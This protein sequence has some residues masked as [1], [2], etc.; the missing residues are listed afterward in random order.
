MLRSA[1]TTTTRPRA[2]ASR[3]EY[4]LFLTSRCSLRV[5]NIPWAEQVAEDTRSRRSRAYYLRPPSMSSRKTDIRSQL[6]PNLGCPTLSRS[7]SRPCKTS[8]V[9]FVRSTRC[10]DSL[11]LSLA[12][13]NSRSRSRSSLLALRTPHSALSL[14]VRSRSTRM[15]ALA[16]ALG[17][18]HSLSHSIR[19]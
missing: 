4:R 5:D 8:I 15:L 6:L 9:S 13:R 11:S 2:V 19:S 18:S 12:I 3:V 10:L 14:S 16:L 17:T 1:T 7:R